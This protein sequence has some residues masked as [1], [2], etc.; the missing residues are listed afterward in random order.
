MTS[1]SNIKVISPE[2]QS[3]K[4]SSIIEL[5]LF[6]LGSYI[7]AQLLSSAVHEIGH[8]LALS[9]IPINFRLVLNPF[10]TSMVMSLSSVPSDSLAFVSAAGTVLELLFGTL[11]VALFW[12]WRSVKLVPLLMV[13]PVSYLTSAGYFLVGVA[14]PEGDTALLVALG[15]PAHVIQLLGVLML[16]FGVIL[17]V[18][19]F[20]LFG[21]SRDDKFRKV[22]TIL[23]LGLVLHGFGMIA[24]ALFFNP[25]EL[26]IGIANV[27]SMTVTVLILAVIFLRG[28][29]HLERIS[30]TKIAVPE[31]YTVLYVVGLAMI[32]IVAELIF[33]N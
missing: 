24:F 15:I 5:G 28:G 17:I 23:F 31:R 19:M 9:T 2:M 3:S 30:H 10:S 1:T 32:F 8:A 12:R 11:A 4:N 25:L 27:V 7:I 29:H 33:L 14:M 22:V 13:A 21:L 18:L 20:P 6:M 26:Y 16:I